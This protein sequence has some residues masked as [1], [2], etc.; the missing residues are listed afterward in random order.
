M[1][2]HTPF[3]IYQH[4]KP[5]SW[6]THLERFQIWLDGRGVTTDEQKRGL[7]LNTLD[8][9]TIR[10][11]KNWIQPATLRT[12]RY[13]DI[14]LKLDAKITP[15]INWFVQYSK[16]IHRTQQPGESGADFMASIKELAESCNFGDKKARLV[17]GQFVSGLRD[18]LV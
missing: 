18:P 11:L 12:M 17:L 15:T 6:A 3:R 16:L 14:V 10:N 7:L 4:N 1:A 2:Q 8:D 9:T 13:E 5:E